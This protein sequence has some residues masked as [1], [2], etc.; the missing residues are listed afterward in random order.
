LEIIDYS[1]LYQ[2]QAIQLWNDT[3]TA[4]LIDENR[5]IKLVLCDENFSSELA[6]LCVDQG[7]LLGFLLS[8]KRIV[9]YMERGLEPERGFVNLIFVKK[10]YQHQ[11]IGTKLMQT[12]EKRMVEKG[13]KNITLAAYSPNYFFPGVDAAAYP[14]AVEFFKKLGYETT[15]EA[16]SMH[17]TLFDYRYPEAVKQ[18]KDEY[19]KKGYNIQ[20]FSYEYTFELL[21][22]LL[23]N[24]G[25]GW[26]RNAYLAILNH[27][28]HDTIKICTDKDGKIVGYCM[29][30]IDGNPARFGP[31]GVRKDLR[32]RGMGSILFNEM[33]YDM[34]SKGIYHVYL[35]W[36]HGDA[37]RFYE[38]QGMKPYRSY[39][40]MKKIIH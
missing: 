20:P 12:A 38:R 27:V 24:F 40:L 21:E 25:A 17:R 3:L 29:R 6:L 37:Q 16:V 36:T 8:T 11:G 39:Q 32:S 19:I 4:D 18:R 14:H 28:A 35:L 22:F 34:L 5:F 7:E 1:P 9:P 26:K 13:T 31:F 23:K 2:K 15:G 30:A 10:G 33:M